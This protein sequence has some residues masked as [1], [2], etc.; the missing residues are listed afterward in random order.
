MRFVN[1]EWYLRA[2]GLYPYDTVGFIETEVIICSTLSQC[3]G[4]CLAEIAY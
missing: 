1:K 4:H 3:L 2:V